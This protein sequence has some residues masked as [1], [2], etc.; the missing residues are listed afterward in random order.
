MKSLCMSAFFSS[1]VRTHQPFLLLDCPPQKPQIAAMFRCSGSGGNGIS[2]R[3]T[4]ALL[5]LDP[6]ECQ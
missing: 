2:V 1:A 5:M 6:S 3:S 4:I